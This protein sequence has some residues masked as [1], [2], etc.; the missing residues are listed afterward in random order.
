MESANNHDDLNA[1][2]F[3]EAPVGIVLAENRVI[4]ACNPEFA[5]MFGF[6]REA[7][8]GQSIAILYPS[9]DEFVRIGEVGTEPLRKTGRYSDERI[10]ARSDGTLFWCRVRGRT[11]VAEGDPLTRAVWSFTDL[12]SNRPIT[13]LSPRERQ[14]MMHLI[15]GSTSKEIAAILSISPR[16]VETYRAKL[17]KKFGAGNVVEL[18]SMLGSMPV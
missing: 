17:L 6:A 7:L 14:I 2:A 1:L 5:N 15:D 11:L 3:E 10:M 8:L 9:F 12:S 4:R 18:L 16:T 13:D